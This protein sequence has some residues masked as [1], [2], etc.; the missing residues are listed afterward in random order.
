M[1]TD[2]D[3]VNLM[4]DLNWKPAA[5]YWKEQA[6]K[7]EKRLD[8]YEKLEKKLVGL[9]PE[10]SEAPFICSYDKKGSPPEYLHVC[11]TYGSDATYCY[12]LKSLYTQQGG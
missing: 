12:T 9:Y 3:K 8:T 4:E 5:Q 11:P 6:E 2:R 1:T 10:H 7:L